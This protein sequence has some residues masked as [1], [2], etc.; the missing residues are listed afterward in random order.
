MTQ[1]AKYFVSNN[2]FTSN[3]AVLRDTETGDASGAAGGGTGDAAPQEE[4][5]KVDGILFKKKN[6]IHFEKRILKVD[7]R[8]VKKH[9]EDDDTPAYYIHIRLDDSDK[10]KFPTFIIR[11]DARVKVMD[12]EIVLSEFAW[13]KFIKMTQLF[14]YSTFIEKMM[15]EDGTS[16]E[17]KKNMEDMVLTDNKLN[18]LNGLTLCGDYITY[19]AHTPATEPYR[20]N[21]TQFTPEADC[22]RAYPT[23]IRLSSTNPQCKTIARNVANT[24]DNMGADDIVDAL[25]ECGAIDD[26][27]AT[28]KTWEKILTPEKKVEN[29]DQ[30]NGMNPQMMMQMMQMMMQMMNNK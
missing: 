2:V 17:V 15:G 9:D 26:T 30:M 27:V 12:N 5:T 20:L 4:M 10:V 7:R 21:P 6:V 18:V 19:E 25:V 28:K 16:I 8:D 13:N 22:V 14:K 3:A 11:G 1:I 23:G 24:W 29:N